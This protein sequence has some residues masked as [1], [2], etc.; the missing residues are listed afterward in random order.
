MVKAD[1]GKP[2]IT[3]PTPWLFKLIGYDPSRLRQAALEV[4]AGRD[5][6]VTASSASRTGRYHSLNVEIVLESDQD[7]LALYEAFALHHE[8]RMVL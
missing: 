2:V 1:P 6:I 8:I 7:R 4:L 5:S 3:Y